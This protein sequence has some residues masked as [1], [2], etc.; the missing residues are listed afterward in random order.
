LTEVLR[1]G[2]KRLLSLAL[3]PEVPVSGWCAIG[4]YPS[5]D[6]HRRGG[7]AQ[8]QG[9]RSRRRLPRPIQFFVAVLVAL[10]A[11]MSSAN[12]ADDPVD[13]ADLGMVAKGHRAT[14]PSTSFSNNTRCLK[15]SPS[16][17]WC[18]WHDT[19]DGAMVQRIDKNTNDRNVID[20]PMIHSVPFNEARRAATA[21][22]PRLIANRPAPRQS[23]P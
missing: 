4:S 14:S 10:R 20:V 8:R 12:H 7:G 11:R 22:P 23:S 6:R 19:K 18:G 16:I 21:S 5:Y 1:N 3:E 9:A 2:A 17:V 15:P 13:E